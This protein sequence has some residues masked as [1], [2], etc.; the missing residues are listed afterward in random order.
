MLLLTSAMLPAGGVYRIAWLAPAFAITLLT[1]ALSARFAPRRVAIALAVAWLVV[2]IIVSG[3][4]S[5]TAM[6]GAPTQ[7]IAIVVA[8]ASVALVFA[9][10]ERFETVEAS[11]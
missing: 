6:F 5:V 4:A 7:L 8:A 11:A 10:R 3:A 9:Q 1:L 2:V